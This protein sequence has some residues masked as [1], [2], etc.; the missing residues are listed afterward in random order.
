MNA[1]DFL[2]TD[3]QTQSAGQSA[4]DFLKGSGVPT[5]NKAVNFL[6]GEPT[7]DP[8][9]PFYQ[10]AVDFLT[11]GH[12]YGDTEQPEKEISF[13]GSKA[14][15]AD[16]PTGDPGFFNDP[17]TW[18]AMGGVAG[19][20][21]AGGVASRLVSAWRE[22]DGRMNGWATEVTK[23]AK[24]GIEAAVKPTT[25][26]NL[27][28][29]FEKQSGKQFAEVPLEFQSTIIPG[30]KE[31]LEPAS[32][33]VSRTIS[34]ISKDF[35]KTFAPLTMGP[36]AKATGAIMREKLGDMARR[37]DMVEASLKQ[38]RKD[39]GR[40]DFSENIDFMDKIEAGKIEE[41]GKDLQ[42][43]AKTIRSVLDERRNQV[44]ALGTGKLQEF[45]ENYFPH[46]W[47]DPEE[48]TNLM[49]DWF[50]RR[51]MEGS[52]AFLRERSVPTIKD[53]LNWRVY[54]S[55]GT[56]VNSFVTEK[57]A[58]ENLGEGGRIG[59]PL[60]PVSSNPVD[61]TVLKL[62]EMDKYIMAHQTIQEMK[63]TGLAKFVRS[64]HRGPDGWVKINDKIATVYA[65][66]ELKAEVGQTI[67]GHYYAPENA[68]TVINNYL[69]PGLRN[70]EWFRGYLGLSNIMNQAQLG[71]SAF[72]L[73]FTSFDAS[74]SKV[75][76]G[77]NQ[78]SEGRPFKAFVSVAESPIAPLTTIFK[79]NKVLKEWYRPG[80]QGEEIGRIVEGLQ[81]AGGRV[82][83]DR[84]YQTRIT[85]KMMDNFKSG[86]LL[87]GVL[88]LPF[89]AI[90]MGARPIMEQIV[91]RQKL[92]VFMDLA[93]DQLSALEAKGAGR[94]EIRDT[95][96]TIWNSVDNRMGQLV[97]DN[98]FWNRTTKD[99]GM[100]SVRS[101]GWNL[102]TFRELGGGMV[103]LLKQPGKII[104]GQYPEMTYRMAYAMALPM[105][106]GTIGGMTHYLMTGE[107]PQELKDYFF[108]KT[109]VTDKDGVPERISFPS[110]MKDVYHYMDK[111]GTAIINKLH[112]AL[113][114]F[115][116]MLQNQDF[117]G[118]EIRNAD[119]PLMKQAIDELKFIGKQSMPFSFSGSKQA[120]KMGASGLG[121]A[122]PFVGIMPAP[123]Y[124][125]RSD[126]QN[127]IF[128]TYQSYK[129]KG[130][131]TQKEWNTAQAKQEIAEAF[132]MGDQDLF[133][134]KVKDAVDKG[135]IPNDKNKLMTLVEHSKLPS[136]VRVFAQLPT[137]YQTRLMNKMTREEVGKYAWYA[138]Q[139]VKDQMNDMTEA[140][141]SFVSDFQDGKIQK[142]VYGQ[143]PQPEPA[144][145]PGKWKEIGE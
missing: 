17:V 23:L 132:R 145:A 21:A 67:L 28:E 137:E 107:S 85:E 93:K 22:F 73:G 83:M 42:P 6:K 128:D 97:Y 123:K 77:L 25:V 121:Q 53:G 15:V 26:K 102:G 130:K 86:N 5:Q 66:P 45:Y 35:K 98:L 19:V 64:G 18:A 88:R 78:L 11:G 144:Q 122:A 14:T 48:G 114:L 75:A 142:P 80:S 135:Y 4:S 2:N 54:D 62:R 59:K 37:G 30:A 70:K 99:L 8:T 47:K 104:K 69:A 46:I 81:Q 140:T 16:I 115:S 89:A 60:E 20:K 100:A 112:P 3:P 55:E 138:H 49:R 43:T 129:G 9:R 39:F 74:I 96:Q 118:T 110:Y 108:P 68:A 58:L 57:E 105:V 76:L 10:K 50:G 31:F 124:I 87:G 131:R 44:Q 32:K 7:K 33:A 106:V 111:P 34:S 24:S 116:S 143:Q 1:L 139:E 82:R 136:D 126:M 65:P 41:I 94:E 12:I 127:Q 95:L 133:W 13:E 125:D 29:T 36:E 101:L 52:K 27:A 91:P 61:L 113:N 120:K 72:H 71:F 109:G 40:M 117:Y 84:F 141:K 103:D 79:G 38:A 56:M 134:E 119:D 63:D 92:G 51:P 90:E